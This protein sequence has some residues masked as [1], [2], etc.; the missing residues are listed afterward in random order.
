MAEEG[1]ADQELIAAARALLD[2]CRQKQLKLA[3]AE[4][5]TGGL[6]A[7]TLTEIPGSSDV[8]DRGFVTYSNAAKRAV[9]GVPTTTLERCGAVS[10]ETAEAMATG[11]LAHAP[12]DLSVSITGIAGPGGGTAEKPVGLVHFAV[13]SRNGRLIHHE[14]RFGDIGRSRVRHASVVAALA[15][16]RD[17]AEAEAPKPPERSE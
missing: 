12:V 10:R 17:L 5:C 2:L 8:L 3:T 14:Q 11:A 15:M 16:L 4:S 13:A 1:L 9:L 6:L 7:A